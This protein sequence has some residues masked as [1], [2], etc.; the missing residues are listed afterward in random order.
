MSRPPA[1]GDVGA[2]SLGRLEALV[3]LKTAWHPVGS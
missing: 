3:E 1:G 2:F